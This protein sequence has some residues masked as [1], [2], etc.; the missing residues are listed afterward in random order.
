M[1]PAATLCALLFFA[2]CS[3]GSD[4]AWTC[5]WD[6]PPAE[7]TDT[8]A[9]REHFARHPERWE[10]AF[11]FLAGNDLDALPVGEYAI[12]D[13]DV[14]AIVS[15][16][17]TKPAA[18]SLFESHRRYIDLQYMIRGRERMGVA[19]PGTA[20]AAGEYNPERDIVFYGTDAPARYAD[21]TPEA[22]FLFFPKDVH[23]PSMRCGERGEVVKKVVVKIRYE[24]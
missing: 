20:L 8:A 5:G 19:A 4:A 17:T 12:A 21:A 9:A 1:R 22:F 10:A 14:Y 24:P 2:A 6:V 23:R 16:Y 18:E 11:G 15:D 3:G 7:L 13:R